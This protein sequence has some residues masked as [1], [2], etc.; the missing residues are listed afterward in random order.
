MFVINKTKLLSVGIM[1]LAIGALTLMMGFS[2]VSAAEGDIDVTAITVSAVDEATRTESVSTIEINNG[3]I[4]MI[5][6]IEPVN[7]TNKTMVWT[8]EDG[9]GSAWID[10]CGQLFATTNGTVTVTGAS[11][12]NPLVLD[13]MIITIT[14]QLEPIDLQTAENYT[15][16]AATGISS[17]GTEIKGDIAANTAD[18]ITGFGTLTLDA[19]G[20]F[21]TSAQVDGKIFLPGYASPTPAELTAAI[22][23]SGSAYTTGSLLVP[24]TETELYAGDIGGQTF[25]AGIY[26]WSNTV[27]IN[28]TVTLDGDATDIWVFQIAGGIT[29]LAGTSVILTGDARPENVFWLTATTVSIGVDCHFEGIV[30]ASTDITLGANSSVNG[31]LLAQTR[32]DLG[33]GTSVVYP[34]YVA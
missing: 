8:V 3:V 20:T 11:Q 19:S 25:T 32:V 12:S 14:N 4:R 10:R 22:G 28:N 1:T 9:T 2:R 23:D 26:K 5:A 24:P 21:S 7:A 31:R 13:T 30:I 29:Q 18:S 16:L 27:T 34:G 6:S 33:V 17:G 15:I